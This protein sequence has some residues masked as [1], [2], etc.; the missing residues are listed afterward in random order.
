ME[1]R[2]ALM[3]GEVTV[4]SGPGKGTTVFV[5]IPFPADQATNTHG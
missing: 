1:E 5:R 4:E 3:N 2:A